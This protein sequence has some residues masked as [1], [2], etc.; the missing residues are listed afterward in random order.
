MRV[1]PFEY[2]REIIKAMAD[3]AASL[4]A[5]RFIGLL[6]FIP[7]QWAANSSSAFIQHMRIN[8]GRAHILV[9]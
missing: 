8:H 3:I 2:E 4:L 9:P 6:R 1:T 5:N 7:V